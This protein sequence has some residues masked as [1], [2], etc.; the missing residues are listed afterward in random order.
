MV[1]AGPPAVNRCG[2]AHLAFE[3]EDVEETLKALLEE[4]GSQLGEVVSA[5]YEDGR[6]AVFVYAADCEGN[7]LELKSW[8]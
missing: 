6:K 1:E 2:F 5:E 3:V 8:H 4:G 7:V